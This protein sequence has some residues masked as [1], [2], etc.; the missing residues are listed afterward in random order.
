[1]FGRGEMPENTVEE[2]A[3]SFL[4]H[5]REGADLRKSVPFRAERRCPSVSVFFCPGRRF[6]S[7]SQDKAFVPETGEDFRNVVC[8][9]A[10]VRSR[11]RFLKELRGFRF[12]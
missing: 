6:G 3:R 10:L 8:Y 4:T 2:G 9:P 1:M 7:T 5:I 12:T 11:K